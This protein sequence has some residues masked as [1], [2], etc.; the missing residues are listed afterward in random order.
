M[1][2]YGFFRCHR[3]YIVNLKWSVK[4]L[5]GQKTHTPSELITK[6]NQRTPYPEK[7]T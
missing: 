3:S 6:I 1:E 4:S 5:R 2:I 7:N